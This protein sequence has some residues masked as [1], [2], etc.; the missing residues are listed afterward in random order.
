LGPL[1]ASRS[2]EAIFSP[3][4]TTTVSSPGDLTIRLHLTSNWAPLCPNWSSRFAMPLRPNLVAPMAAFP[5]TMSLG[6]GAPLD[7]SPPPPHPMHHCGVPSASH[8]GCHDRVRHGAP[9]HPRVTHDQLS[10]TTFSSTCHP[11]QVIGKVL[12]LTRGFARSVATVGHRN[13]GTAVTNGHVPWSLVLVHP[14]TPHHH[15]G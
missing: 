14:A 3:S 15:I 1:L 9:P 4:S 13:A 5:F 2:G 6:L 11:G 7:L 10:L 12:M 8:R